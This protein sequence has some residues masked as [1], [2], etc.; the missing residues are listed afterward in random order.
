MATNGPIVHDLATAR[1]LQRLERETPVEFVDR[2]ARYAVDWISE[3]DGDLDR[4]RILAAYKDRLTSLL[5][6][7]P[8]SSP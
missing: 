7:H 3:R 4:E 8:S 2:L 1:E 6:S 5:L